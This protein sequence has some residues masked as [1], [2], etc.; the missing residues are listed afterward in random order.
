MA[1]LEERSAQAG[2]FA[3]AHG[4]GIE[5]PRRAGGTAAVDVAT[6]GDS[7]RIG[8]GRGWV[9]PEVAAPAAARPHNG[10]GLGGA[11][12]DGDAAVAGGRVARG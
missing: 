4:A 6:A 3:T 8:A 12:L 11:L 5:A 7:L 2:L 1:D 10:V 9:A